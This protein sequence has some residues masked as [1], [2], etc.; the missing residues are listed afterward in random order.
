[1]SNL[2]L[3]SWICPRGSET[4]REYKRAQTGNIFCFLMEKILVCKL[5][6][7]TKL[8]QMTLHLYFILKVSA[9]L[10]ER[11]RIHFQPSCHF[12]CLRIWALVFLPKP[13][14]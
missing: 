13:S 8:D 2:R 7:R 3:I 11:L 12:K 6:K 10:F 9:D 1:M 4:V 5:N 14:P